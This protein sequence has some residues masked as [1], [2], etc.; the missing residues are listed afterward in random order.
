MPETLMWGERGLGTAVGPEIKVFSVEAKHRVSTAVTRWLRNVVGLAHGT[1]SPG[2]ILSII[3]S[4][5]TPR[6]CPIA[7]IIL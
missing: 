4:M 6:A 7:D 2:L 5:S 1:A 3:L